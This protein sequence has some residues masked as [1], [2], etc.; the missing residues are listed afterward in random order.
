MSI[1][2]KTEKNNAYSNLLLNDAIEKNKLSG[3]D[4]GL[5]TELV[6]GVLQRKITLDFYLSDFIDPAKKVDT[7]VQNLLRL[8]IYQMIYLDKI[9]Q[10]AI[11]FEA[12]EIAKKKDMLEL[13]NLSMEFCVTLNAVALKILQTSKTISNVLVLK[14]A[15]QNGW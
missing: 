6:Y 2:D 15:C 11:L 13:V 12:A 9:P 1:L 4:A 14:S 3:P 7:W 5:L 8:S 10:H